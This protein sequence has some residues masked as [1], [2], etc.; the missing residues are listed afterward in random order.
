MDRRIEQDTQERCRTD[1]SLAGCSAEEGCKVG[2]DP[3]VELERTNSSGTTEYQRTSTKDVP[4][5]DVP[6]ED[7]LEEFLRA[8][9]EERQGNPLSY[10]VALAFRRDA[11]GE[12]ALSK[13]AVREGALDRKLHRAIEHFQRLQAQRKGK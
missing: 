7:L 8:R 10:D 9:E 13:L 4:F 2:P 11:S 1:P 5:S 12:D 6:N 3:R